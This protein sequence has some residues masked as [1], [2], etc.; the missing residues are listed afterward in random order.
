VLILVNQKD[1]QGWPI[2]YLSLG[3]HS[4][5]ARSLGSGREMTEMVLLS[6]V[7]RRL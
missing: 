6:A 3:E 7:L 1:K 4:L 2:V 5:D